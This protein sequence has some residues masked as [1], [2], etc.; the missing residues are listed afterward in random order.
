MSSS[1]TAKNQAC[2]SAK[3]G[4]VPETCRP[5][6]RLETPREL[7][8]REPRDVLLI[9]PVELLLVEDGV[10][11]ADAVERERLDQLV[12]AEQLAIART[13]RP[14]EQREEVHHRFGKERPAS[15][16]P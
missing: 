2:R 8:R 15:R 9:E 14:A 5:E 16:T 10:T 7:V 1:S 12:L 4:V 3:V 11:A 13:G 6:R